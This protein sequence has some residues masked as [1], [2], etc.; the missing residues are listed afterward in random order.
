MHGHSTVDAPLGGILYN[1]T[2]KRLE[3]V[4]RASAA[5]AAGGDS[6]VCEPA[7]FWGDL[8]P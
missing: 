8:P 5:A 6:E 2:P 1:K 4:S 3:N 7:V